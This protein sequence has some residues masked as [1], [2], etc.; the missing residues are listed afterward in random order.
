VRRTAVSREDVLASAPVAWPLH[1]LMMPAQSTGA[2]AVVLASPARAAR[3]LGRDAVLTGFG[4]A[5]GAYTW[6]GGWLRD[7]AATTYRAAT[8]AYAQAGLTDPGQQVRY[9][10]L[11]APTP[12]LH[13]PYLGALGLA[14]SLRP[15]DVNASGGLRSNYPGLANGALRLL[16]AVERLASG[17]RHSTAVVHSVDTITG[18]VSEDVTV[19]TVEA[20]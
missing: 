20:A 5:T 11:S 18:T 14:K 17:D 16:E 10:E 3:A 12:A 2:V 6:T 9:A 4:H 15:A 1:E 13:E 8:A 19:L 7:P